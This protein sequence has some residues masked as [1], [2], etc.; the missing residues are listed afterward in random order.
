M[1]KGIDIPIDEQKGIFQTYLWPAFTCSWYGRCDRNYRDDQLFPEVLSSGQYVDVLLDD[2]KAAI[3]F[4]DVLPERTSNNATVE[5]Y[6]AVKLSTLYS[7]ITERATEY[8]IG[9]VLKWLARG[10]KFTVEGIMT[11]YESWSKWALVKKEDNMHPF[12][13]FKIITNVQYIITC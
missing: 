9:E 10:N 3:S 5:I 7:T 1:S 12:F 8:V 13:L 11:G 6:F 4:F 2:T